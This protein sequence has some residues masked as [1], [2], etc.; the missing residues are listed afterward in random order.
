MQALRQ[1]EETVWKVNEPEIMDVVG[2]L[3][4]DT[5]PELIESVKLCIESGAREM[6]LDCY[7]LDYITSAGM[8]AILTL[9]GAMQAAQGKLAVCNLKAQPKAMFEACGYDQVIAVYGDQDRAVLAMAA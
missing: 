9:A 8:R 7:E 4:C 1:I 3:D 2:Y 5:A 6:I